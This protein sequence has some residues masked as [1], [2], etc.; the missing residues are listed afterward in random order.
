M[1]HQRASPRSLVIARAFASSTGSSARSNAS[2]AAF[3]IPLGGH[4]ITTV[5][6]GET[7]IEEASP[8]APDRRRTSRR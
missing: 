2:E 7:A 1:G 5:E 4:D 3:K 8:A 6:V